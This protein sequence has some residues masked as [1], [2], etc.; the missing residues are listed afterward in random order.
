MICKIESA[1]YFHS[2]YAHCKDPEYSIVICL[3]KVSC[4]DNMTISFLNPYGYGI[5]DNHMIPD[6]EIEKIKQI[7][8]VKA[9]NK[10]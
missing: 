2:Y 6:A 1:S 7:E 9:I 5:G 8:L 3:F 4:L 10:E